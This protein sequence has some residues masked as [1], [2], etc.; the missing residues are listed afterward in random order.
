M[1]RSGGPPA[2]FRARQRPSL[3][4][5]FTGELSQRDSLIRNVRAIHGAQ[6]AAFRFTDDLWSIRQSSG[7]VAASRKEYRPRVALVVTLFV[8]HPAGLRSLVQA[9]MFLQSGGMQIFI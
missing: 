1:V 7:A 5:E 3:A 8:T 4:R 9:R 2:V 6:L